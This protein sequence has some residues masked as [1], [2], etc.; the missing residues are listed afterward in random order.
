MTTHTSPITIPGFGETK[1]GVRHFF[2]TRHGHE[3]AAFGAHATVSV[4][5]VHGTDVLILDRPVR[6][7]DTFPGGWDA[8][9]TNQPGIVITVRTA[10]CVP[11]LVHDPSQRLVAAIHAGWRGAVAGILPKTLAT[12]RQRFGSRAASLTIGIGPSAGRC[13]Y[14]VDEPVLAPL[15]TNFPEWRRVAR[16]TDAGKAFLDLR[17]LIRAQAE[18]EGVPSRQVFTVDLCTICNPD[19]FYSYRRE[20]TASTAMTSGIMLIP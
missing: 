8:L 10:D 4:R 3:A 20:G 17:G 19:L 16:E 14:E 18:G 5:Q 2:G 7:D 12:L 6:P 1:A 13:C 11:V 15:R 9:V